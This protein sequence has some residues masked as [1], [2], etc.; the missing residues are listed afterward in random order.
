MRGTLRR[1]PQI[2][3]HNKSA[4]PWWVPIVLLPAAIALHGLAQRLPDRW[5]RTRRRT[6]ILATG[7]LLF[8]ANFGVA[9]FALTGEA[10]LLESPHVLILVVPAVA[11][12]AILR[13]PAGRA[14]RCA[15]ES[16]CTSSKR[17]RD[18]AD[19]VRAD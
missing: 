6:A 16:P 7:P 1:G 4:V 9:A 12:G 11:Y 13:F 2:G 10:R 17:L 5:S 15:L 3:P 18:T 8:V 19:E 14:T